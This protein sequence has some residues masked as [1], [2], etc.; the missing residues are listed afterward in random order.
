MPAREPSLI[1][2]AKA[3]AKWRP[4]RPWRSR[5]ESRL[6]R[7]YTWQWL[8][9]HGPW[10]SGRAL[11]RW[12]VVSHTYIQK[13]ARTLSR[14][15]NDFLRELGHSDPPTV[16]ALSRAREESKNQRERGLLRMPRCWKKV[17][18]KL[19]NEVIRA[20]VPAKPTVVGLGADNPVSPAPI[21]SKRQPDY[22]AALLW[23]LRIE[24]KRKKAMGSWSLSPMRRRRPGMPF[25]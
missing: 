19:G 8:L 20:V 18:F 21:N 15:E 24:G 1:N 12:L 2:L 6:I 25:R 17:E 23:H 9:G 13:L 10:C 16:D 14:D 4:P 3:R 22:N 11:A 5:S 7:M